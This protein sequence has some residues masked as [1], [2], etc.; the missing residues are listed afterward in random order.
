MNMNKRHTIRGIARQTGLTHEQ[1]RR[2]VEALIELWSTALAGGKQVAID[3]FLILEVKLVR[4]HGNLPEAAHKETQI[5]L[6]AQ[7]ERA[8][9]DQI[10]KHL[11]AS[12]QHLGQNE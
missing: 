2:A 4:R 5:R 11:H 12:S 9:R 6:R 8:L 10:T 7:T 3:N 1:S